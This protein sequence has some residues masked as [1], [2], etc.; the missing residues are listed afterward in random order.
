MPGRVEDTARSPKCI[1]GDLNRE[2]PEQ[3]WLVWAYK[4]GAGLFTRPPN[5]Q[6]LFLPHPPPRLALSIPRDSQIQ[7]CLRREPQNPEYWNPQPETC[8]AAGL[9]RHARA[10]LRMC[11]MRAAPSHATPPSHRL[12]LLDSDTTRAVGNFLNLAR[13]RPLL[14]MLLPQISRGPGGTGVCLVRLPAPFVPRVP[15]RRAGWEGSGSLRRRGW[16]ARGGERWAEGGW[17]G[18]DV[19]HTQAA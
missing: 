15:G 16:G 1:S 14:S 3:I 2:A 9:A 12:P 10:A 19:S 4:K 13:T 5:L 6:H 7:H 17:E 8:C 18:P 11:P